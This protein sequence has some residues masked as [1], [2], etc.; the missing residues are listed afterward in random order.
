MVRAVDLGG[1]DSHRTV[2][3]HGD[4]GDCV[5]LAQLRDQVQN[6]LRPADGKS[7]NDHCPRT[8]HGTVDDAGK[9]C[10]GVVFFVEAVAVS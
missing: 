6:G 7:R 10:L 3:K 5:F 8:L 9:L 4:V 1:V 2:Q